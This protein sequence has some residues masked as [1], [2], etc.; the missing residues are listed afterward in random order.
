MSNQAPARGSQKL[1]AQLAKKGAAATPDEVKA[2]VAAP[3][4]ADYKLL[5]WLIRGIPPVYFE[6]EAM[7]QVK[8]QHLGEAVNH[9]V[10]N[11]AIRDINILINGIPFPDIAQVT[12]TVAES[13]EV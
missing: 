2:A 1:L 13:G 8:P 12:V 10:A 4:T 9:F 6:L 3:T 5:R 7:L 11:S